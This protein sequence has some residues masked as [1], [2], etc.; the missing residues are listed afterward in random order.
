MEGMRLMDSFPFEGGSE[1]AADKRFVYAN[2][3][4][5]TTARGQHPDQGGFTLLSARNGTLIEHGSW[6]CPGN[7]NDIQPISKTVAVIAHHN[8]RCNLGHGVIFVDIS[9]PRSP[10]IISKLSFTGN[11]AH[12]VTPHPRAPFI[13]VSP[14]GLVNGNGEEVIINV[15]DPRNP[16]IAATF[17]PNPAGCHDVAMMTRDD[18]TFAFCSGVIETSIWDVSDPVA[19]SI[20]A[21]IHNPATEFMYVAQPSPDGRYLAIVDEAFAGHECVAGAGPGGVWLYDIQELTTPVLV[22]RIP[23]PQRGGAAV[24]TTDDLTTWC[25]SHGIAWH[26]RIAD[27]LAVTWYSAGLSVFDVS[28][29]LAPVEIATFQAS[30]SLAEAVVWHR[31]LLFSND[32]RRGVD[33]FAVPIGQN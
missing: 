4:D 9:R 12:T 26:P 3:L 30:D 25:A 2:Q 27:M 13:Y 1:I 23:P 6:H 19:P 5:G 16:S 24:A 17:Q 20:V 31:G 15:S 7:D 8:N 29:P 11:T 22:G 21:R 32:L 28:S 18:R 33:V 14:G 10:R